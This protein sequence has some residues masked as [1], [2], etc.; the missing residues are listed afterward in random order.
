M[1]NDDSA[2]EPQTATDDDLYQSVGEAISEIL[3]ETQIEIEPGQRVIL[4]EELIERFVSIQKAAGA[5]SQVSVTMRPA[6]GVESARSVKVRN[7]LVNVN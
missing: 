6:G 1:E 4:A 2:D 3:A 7:A 5:T